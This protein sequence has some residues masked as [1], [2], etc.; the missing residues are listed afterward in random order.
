[1]IY[2]F[3]T[4][5]NLDIDSEKSK[6]EKS[7]IGDIFD[8]IGIINEGKSLAFKQI[9]LSQKKAIQSG[10][11]K[12]PKYTNTYFEIGKSM[13]KISCI[14]LFVKNLY[15]Y[16]QSFVRGVLEYHFFKHTEIM[17]SN[18]FELRV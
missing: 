12:F 18:T 4:N 15:Q 6:A 1:M 7:K 11:S 17:N 2:E 9:Q 13:P 5:T 10:N 14:I 16:L 8:D 3:T